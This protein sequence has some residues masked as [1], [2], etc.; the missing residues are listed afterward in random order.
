MFGFVDWMMARRRSV[1]FRLAI[2]ATLLCVVALALDIA[3]AALG[4]QTVTFGGQ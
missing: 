1:D 2:A 4:L 3:I